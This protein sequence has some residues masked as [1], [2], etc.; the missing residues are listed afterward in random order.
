MGRSGSVVEEAEMG[1]SGGD[2][3]E[4]WSGSRKLKAGGTAWGAGNRDQVPP[5]VQGEVWYG[6]VEGGGGGRDGV[7]SGSRRGWGSLGRPWKGRRRGIVRIAGEMRGGVSGGGG[8]GRWSRSEK[9]GTGGWKVS[10]MLPH[11]ISLLI[12]GPKGSK[13]TDVSHVHTLALSSVVV[14]SSL[15]FFGCIAN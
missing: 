15:R 4:R 8:D 3:D 10:V 9:L 6:T 11:R 7:W 5:R 13:L 14:R 12:R 1:D 2:G